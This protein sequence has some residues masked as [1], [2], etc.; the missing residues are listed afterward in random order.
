MNVRKIWT[1]LFQKPAGRLVLFLLVGGNLPC[2]HP[3]AEDAAAEAGQHARRQP[4]HA[5]KELFLQGGHPA[6]LPDRGHAVSARGRQDR[7]RH[8]HSQAAATH[9]ADDLRHQGTIRQRMVSAVWPA[10]SL[11]AG[12]HGGFHQHRHADHRPC[13]RGR[14]ERRARDHPR[15]HG[16][17]WRSPEVSGSRAHRLRPPVVPCFSGRQGTSHLRVSA[18]LRPEEFRFLGGIGRLRGPARIRREVRQI[19]RSQG[20]SCRDDFGGSGRVPG[21]D[22]AHIASRRRDAAQQWRDRQRLFRG[23]ASRRATLLE[24][25][26]GAA[27]QGPVLRPR[28][29]GHHVLPL[30]HANGRSGQSHRRPF[31]FRFHRQPTRFTHEILSTPLS[32]SAFSPVA[33]RRRKSGQSSQRKFPAPWLR[34]QKCRKSA[35][36]R[37]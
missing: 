10:A 28:S 8:A 19:R 15:G 25:T 6:A 37:R 21:N 2:F 11:R 36:R 5:G 27:R 31:C 4:G 17:S 34:R 20:D 30:R 23:A 13:H 7:A 22:H 33:L 24:A 1:E 3:D 9:P 32:W 12:E 29:R 35:R 26:S 16:G 18:R 14:L